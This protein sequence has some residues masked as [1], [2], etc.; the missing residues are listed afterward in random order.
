MRTLA[1]A[2]LA[3]ALLLGGADL[4]AQQTPPYRGTLWGLPSDLLSSA[5]QT[6]LRSVTYLGLIER[7]M[8]IVRDNRFGWVHEPV[9]VFDVS[10]GRINIE[11][12]VYPEFGGEDAAR[13]EAERYAP[14]LGRIPWATMSRVREIE[15]QKEGTRVASAFPLWWHDPRAAGTMS[16]HSDHALEYAV[17]VDAKIDSVFITWVRWCS[18][19]WA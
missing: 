1:L 16:I 17:R 7:D 9:H 19:T 3:V 8:Q 11:F 14:I 5:D 13:E 2:A 12:Q 18:S 10:F 15:I 4:H 6:A